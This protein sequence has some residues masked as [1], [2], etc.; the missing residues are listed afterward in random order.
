VKLKS[1]KKG[2]WCQTSSGINRIGFGN[3]SGFLK[4]ITTC[5]ALPIKNIK[6]I[7]ELLPKE[8]FR[9]S[10][11]IVNEALKQAGE[12]SILQTIFHVISN[13]SE[14]SEV[15]LMPYQDLSLRSR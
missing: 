10:N 7:I 6:P 5:L 13:A 11:K 9:L 15:I 3:Q 1:C 4:K 14:R 2:W 12:Q 8:N